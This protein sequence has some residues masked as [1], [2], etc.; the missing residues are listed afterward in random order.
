MKRYWARPRIVLGVFLMLL[1]LVAAC[2]SSR[3]PDRVHILTWDGDVNPVMAR[4]VDR[5]IDTAE[6]S[7][8]R[9]VVLRLD[10]PGG[11]DSAMR[12][13]IQRIE[14]SRVPVIV[15]VSPSG[16]RAAS[17]GTF[18]TMAGHVAAMAP[19]TTIGAATPVNSDGADIEGALGRKVENDAV[20]YIRGIA[21]LRGRNADW[22]ESAVREAAAVNQNEAVALDVVD[23][24]AQN[25]DDLLRQ[26]DGRSVQVANAAGALEAVT[27]RTAGA[28]TLENDVNFFEAL[29]NQLA[30][31]NIAFLLLS[32]GGL[33]LVSEIFHP[34]LV[35][36]IFGVIALAL[37]YFSLGALPTNWAGVGLILFG[38]VLI[39]AEIFVT[40]FGALGIGGIIALLVGGLIL[41]GGGG[42]TGMQVSRWLVIGTTAAIG[43]FLLVFIGS[44]VRLRRMPA[45]SG[46]EA[47]VGAKGV[48]RSRLDAHGVIW[49][50]GERWDA[51]AEDPPIEADT[52]VIVLGKEG[53]TLRVKRD[54]ASI[55]LLPPAP[56]R[57][58]QR[59]PDPT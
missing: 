32:L 6:D 41:T 35:A 25:I 20:A 57:E 50:A 14:S 9:A 38:F 4:Y 30:N 5:G 37:A 23:F 49:V 15:Y 29:L 26:S 44:I 36:G 40:G 7:A 48:A 27:L 33:A 21:E 28:A 58:P 42:D 19:N 18:I 51:V 3:E 59:Q 45:Q 43:G 2:S 13:I 1:G 55:K 39:T 52:P 8:A 46:R 10:T 11:L 12:D 54:P 34:T 17:A 24:V 22:A 47:L 53:L 56:P 31:P 16:A